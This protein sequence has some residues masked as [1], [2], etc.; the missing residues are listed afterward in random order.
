MQRQLRRTDLKMLEQN[1][2]VARV[3]G[4][5]QIASFQCVGCAGAQIA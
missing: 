3:L 2:G 5:N 4:R 1:S